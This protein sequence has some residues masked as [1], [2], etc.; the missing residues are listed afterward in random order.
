[1]TS[2]TPP[3]GPLTP[4]VLGIAGTLLMAAISGGSRNPNWI[5]CSRRTRRSCWDWN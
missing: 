3:F 4:L 2:S 5:A 1:M